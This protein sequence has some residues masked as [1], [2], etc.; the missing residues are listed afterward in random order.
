MKKQII[1]LA[2]LPM[3]SHAALTYVDTSAIRALPNAEVNEWDVF[4]EA[5]VPGFN[6]GDIARASGATITQNTPGAFLTSG[7]NIYSPF[8]TLSFA[9]SDSPTYVDALSGAF[10][11][12]VVLQ[13]STLGTAIDYSSMSLTYLDN[14]SASAQLAS[15]GFQHQATTTNIMTPGGPATSTDDLV[16]YQWDLTGLNAVS[17]QITFAAAGSSMSLDQVVLDTASTDR[18]FVTVVPEL[19]STILFSISASLLVLRRRRNSP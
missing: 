5:N 4:T 19:N 7:G 1:I 12:N 17:Y 13:F 9:I 14:N 2:L 16:A 18:A 3:V 11:G 6:M 8:L 10:V 15:S